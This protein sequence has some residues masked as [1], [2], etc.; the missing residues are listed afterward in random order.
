MKARE[1][2]RELHNGALRAK[3][4][5]LD[6]PP[7]QFKARELHNGALPDKQAVPDNSQKSPAES[8]VDYPEARPR[9]FI[10]YGDGVGLVRE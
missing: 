3:E 10:S 9:L 7:P 2:D 5:V 1:L 4:A 6:S 8:S